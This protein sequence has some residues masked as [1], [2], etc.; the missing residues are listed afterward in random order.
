MSELD[1]FSGELSFGAVN[2]CLRCFYLKIT[3]TI[4]TLELKG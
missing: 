2:L 4:D 3:N 1:L